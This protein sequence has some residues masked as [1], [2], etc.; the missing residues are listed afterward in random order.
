MATTSRMTS[1]GQMTVPQPVRERLGLAPGD[2]VT[3]VPDASG[4]HVEKVPRSKR[5]SPVDK[6]IGF[7]KKYPGVDTDELMKEL[8]GR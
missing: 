7:S 1:K 4:Y 5:R 2:D 8:R 3:W 6:W